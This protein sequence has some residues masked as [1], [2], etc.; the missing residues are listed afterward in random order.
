MLPCFQHSNGKDVFLYTLR[1]SAGTEVEISN[2]G[3]IIRALR[4]KLPEREPND[5]VLGLDR[6]ED[7]LS[8]AYLNVYPYLGAV[9][10]R[11]GNRIGKGRFILDGKEYHLATNNGPDHLHGGITGFDKKV[12]NTVSVSETG[13]QPHLLLEY[14]SE[15]GEEGYPGRL[16]VRLLFELNE[17]QELTYSFEAVCEQPTIVNL[18]HHSYF[19]FRNGAG[20]CADY[21]LQIAADAILEQDSNFVTTGNLL[22]VAES[23]WDFRQL[24]PIDAH[25]NAETGFDQSFVRTAEGLVA[26]A[27]KVEV[28]DAGIRMELLTSEP[29]VH[30]YTARWLG[31]IAGKNGIEYGPFSGFCLETQVHP[32]A[33]NVPSFP[34]TI[35]RPGETYRTRT[36][37]RFSAC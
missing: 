6:M 7:Y 36:S 24:R 1:N 22:P 5:V 33:I 12:W 32:N 25:W 29:V 27:A 19:N 28:K 3:A 34:N 9:I 30:L 31:P 26:P 18:T 23:N 4:V 8:P 35:L 11:Y 13:V 15:D 20:T 2:Y 17:H 21:Q 14:V 10:G 37:Y 16:R